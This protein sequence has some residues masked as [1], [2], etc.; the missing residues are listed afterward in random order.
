MTEQAIQLCAYSAAV[1]TP[2]S[3]MT[4]TYINV[5]AHSSHKYTQ[6]SSVQIPLGG[7]QTRARQLTVYTGSYGDTSEWQT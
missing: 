4:L 3:D 1:C 7:Q 2:D 6:L 5:G